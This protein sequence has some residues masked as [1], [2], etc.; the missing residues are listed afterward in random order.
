MNGLLVRELTYLVMCE[1]VEAVFAVVGAHPA[2][3]HPAEWELLHP[4]VHDRVV[5]AEA[6]A[7]GVLG[8]QVRHLVPPREHV[9]SQRLVPPVDQLDRLL[10]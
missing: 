3:A 1:C 7:G 9:Q 5:D 8:E 6:A 10:D 4:Q 2:G